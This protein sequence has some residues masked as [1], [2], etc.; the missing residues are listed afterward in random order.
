RANQLLLEV[1]EMLQDARDE[2]GFAE[3]QFSEADVQPFRAA[4]EKAAGE[5]R[6]AFALRQ[7]L[8]DNI[9]EPPDER[10]AALEQIIVHTE[11]AKAMLKAETARIEELRNLERNAPT[12]LAGMPPLI[13][14][15]ERR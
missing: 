4:I 5:L 12:I 11:S 3:A 15:A 9:P 10:K 6:S 8:D 14:A 1:D 13:E 2:L 7:K